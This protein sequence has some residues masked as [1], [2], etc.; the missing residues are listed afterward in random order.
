MSDRM[1]TGP[2]LEQ[3]RELISILKELGNAGPRDNSFKQWRQV[4]LTLLQRVWAGDQARAARFRRIPFSAPSSRADAKTVRDSY[5]KGVVEANAY[6]ESLAQEL[7]NDARGPALNLKRPPE[8]AAPSEFKPVAP[9]ASHRPAAPPPPPSTS[10]PIEPS[11]FESMGP[12][13]PGAA[14]GAADEAAHEASRADAAPVDE[15]P[16]P[17]RKPAAA[18]RPDAA[19]SAPRPRQRLKDMLGFSDEEA[20]ASGTPASSSAPQSPAASRPRPAAPPPQSVVS[21]SPPSRPPEASSAPAPTREIPP[22]APREERPAPPRSLVPVP[23][24]GADPDEEIEFDFDFPD[25]PATSAAPAPEPPAATLREMIDREPSAGAPSPNGAAREVTAMAARLDQLGV[26][27]ERRAMVRAALLDLADQMEAPPVDWAALRQAFAF[28]LEY[29]Q[30]AR[31][32]IPMMVP[33]LD[34]AA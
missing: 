33:F 2:A 34:Q 26:P 28:V 5:V 31:R 4:T 21:V 9:A 7:E 32:V 14:D 13:S 8:V 10:G 11:P 17:E 30:I 20:A 12:S 16:A 3:L 23:P 1:P 27:K 18:S 29:P 6:L 19:R 25:L 24:P 22:P 15:A